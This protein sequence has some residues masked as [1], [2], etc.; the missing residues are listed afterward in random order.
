MQ[1]QSIH[2]SELEDKRAIPADLL[3]QADPS[4]DATA[5]YLPHSVAFGAYSGTRLVGVCLIC[6]PELNIL[7][8]ANLSVEQAAQG[9]GIGRALLEHTIA[10]LRERFGEEPP[11]QHSAIATL[12]IR[13]GNSSIGQLALY[14]KVGFRI[15]GVEPNYFG[16]H[17]PEPIYENG[18]RCLDRIVL[19]M[20][21]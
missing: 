4:A 12:K 8:I 5:R 9:Q 20:N 15:V 13:T 10:A 3:L 6:T 16:E 17:Y 19:Q 11:A 7:E 2:F 1:S 18:I 14:Q 21:L